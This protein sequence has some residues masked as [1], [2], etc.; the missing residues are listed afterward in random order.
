MINIML[1]LGEKKHQLNVD[2]SDTHMIK[3]WVTN[4]RKTIS[5]FEWKVS[6]HQNEKVNSVK[7][8]CEATIGT[9]FELLTRAI[10]LYARH[11]IARSNM[12]IVL[13]SHAEAN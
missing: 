9:H 8:Q 4:T 2:Q 1:L 13:A 6:I 11:A 5:A 10:Y 3:I 12:L 7:W